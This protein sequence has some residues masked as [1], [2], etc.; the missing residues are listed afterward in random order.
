M[1]DSWVEQA[2]HAFA[3]VEGAP[4]HYRELLRPL[5]LR[6][7]TDVRLRPCVELLT[8]DPFFRHLLAG[9]APEPFL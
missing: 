2:E 7:V 8:T 5:V 1:E 9:N 6:A 4:E 3:V